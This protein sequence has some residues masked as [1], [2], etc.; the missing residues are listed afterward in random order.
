MTQTPWY[1]QDTRG[2]MDAGPSCSE[3]GRCECVWSY[4]D[5][6]TYQGLA[7]HQAWEREHGDQDELEC[8]GLSYIYCNPDDGAE[9]LCEDCAL[10]AGITV[11]ATS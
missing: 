4:S 3:C 10:K 5:R 7:V 2:Y 11:E 8:V 1:I 6:L 9:N